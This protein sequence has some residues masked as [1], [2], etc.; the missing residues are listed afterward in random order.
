MLTLQLCLTHAVLEC[1]QKPRQ[2][3]TQA[4]MW[5]QNLSDGLLQPRAPSQLCSASRLCKIGGNRID[6]N[7]WQVYICVVFSC[8]LGAQYV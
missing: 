2:L 7:I 6:H 8:S 3:P 5:V 4:C 1:N